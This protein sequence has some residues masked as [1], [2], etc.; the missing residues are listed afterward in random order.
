MSDLRL[1]EDGSEISGALVP[2][3]VAIETVSEGQNGNG[4]CRCVNGP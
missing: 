1:V 4:E 3:A 2:K